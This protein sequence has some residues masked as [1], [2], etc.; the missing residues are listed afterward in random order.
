VGVWRR[1]GP[2]FLARA[3]GDPPPPSWVLV[4]LPPQPCLAASGI[5]H[6]WCL[7]PSQNRTCAFHAS[8]SP[9]PFAQAT[10]GLRL[11]T[12]RG[13][14]KGYRSTYRQNCSQEKLGR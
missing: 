1:V 6:D 13:P 9:P 5:V 7:S 3:A 8:G 2:L 11:T 4:W 14:A 12:R 10:P